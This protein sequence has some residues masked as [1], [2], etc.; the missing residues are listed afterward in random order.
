MADY[1]SI[2]SR[3]MSAPEATD[4]AWRRDVY[5][6]ARNMLV[7]QLRARPA[8]AAELAREQ[9]A[10]DAAIARVEAEMRQADGTAGRDEA[11]GVPQR[12]SK[13]IAA[14]FRLGHASWIALAVVVAALGAGA[15]AYWA[16][17]ARRPAPQPAPAAAAAAKPAPPASATSASAAP[18]PPPLQKTAATS[19]DGDLPPG[20]DGGST[21]A[22]MP[23]VFRR[24]PTF[25]RTLQ[26]VGT[27]I[28][29]K[30]Q[31]YLYLI[32]PNN[33]ALRYGIGV[34]A[35]CADIAGLRHIASMA[36]WPAW[37]PPPEMLARNPSPLPGGP[38]NPLGARLLQLDDSK[39]RI[40]G[41]N[42]P[43]TIG[44]SVIFGCFR[45]VNDD[46]ADLFGRVKVN[47]A[48]IV[49]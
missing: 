26:P 45:L 28:I 48:V 24:Q 46:I 17:S 49:N 30:L 35:Q 7:T 18:N 3:A 27:V 21:D 36:E 25:Y 32:R 13:P 33:V 20:V 37:Q 4:A 31:H 10:L 40:H 38:G 39:A 41:T 42:A 9:S 43:R 22:D 34:G 16:G 5:G 44:T 11:A 12:K 29:D 14:P 15:Y 2:L 23:Y 1:Y 6:R 19:K 8:A 47:T